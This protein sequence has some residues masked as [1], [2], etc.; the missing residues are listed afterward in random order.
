MLM[1][2]VTADDFRD[3]CLEFI[4]AYSKQYEKTS[5]ARQNDSLV[6]I[7]TIENFTYPT[8]YKDLTI[9]EKRKLLFDF[10]SKEKLQLLYDKALDIVNQTSWSNPMAFMER[11]KKN[12]DYTMYPQ[13]MQSY[14]KEYRRMISLLC[15]YL[16]TNEFDYIFQIV[17]LFDEKADYGIFWII[18][19]DEIRALRYSIEREE[20]DDF[21]A[22][23]YLN[24]IAEDEVFDFQLYV[25]KTAT[26]IR[27][28][29]ECEK[30]RSLA[31]QRL[32]RQVDTGTI[33]Y[34]YSKLDGS[35]ST[36]DSLYQKIYVLHIAVD[37]ERYTDTGE[38]QLMADDSDM[39]FDIIFLDQKSNIVKYG[40]NIGGEVS[41]T[42]KYNKG[43]TEVLR[44]K[45]DYIL[46]VN[47]FDSVITYMKEDKI[48]VYDIDSDK[49]QSIDRYMEFN[50][51]DITN[52]IT[53]MYRS[54]SPVF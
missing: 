7:P 35:K 54:G 14:S 20:F 19:R 47:L 23:E 11:D 28:L 31:N 33:R 8:S 49:K 6:Y 52:A 18:R 16:E 43:L 50:R 40:R 27:F 4:S 15:E 53:S 2:S 42:E 9:P 1:I 44:Y 25:S 13:E 51:Q 34:T 41:F 37:W 26:N 36:A 30:K 46:R 3:S 10:L 21:S 48:Y 45:P 5:I 12:K 22:N 39:P 24:R 32:S 29:Q 38:I 17:N